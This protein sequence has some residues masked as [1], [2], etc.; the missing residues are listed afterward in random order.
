MEKILGSIENERSGKNRIKCG[1][2]ESY[3]S[4]IYLI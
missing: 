3:Q 4:K 1:L 2:R